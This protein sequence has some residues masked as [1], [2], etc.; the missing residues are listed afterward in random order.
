MDLSL[1]PW[2]EPIARQ[3]EPWLPALTI[4]GIVM[5]LASFIAIPWLLVRMP[6]DY[7]SVDYQPR[8]ERAL[9][10][11]VVWFAR[12][13]LAIVLLVAG[14]LML[15]LPGQGL[16]TI[17]IAI[18][19]ST[20]PGKYRLERA[21]MRRPGVYRAANWIRRKYNRPPLDYPGGRQGET[22]DAD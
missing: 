1:P 14:L 19:T 2:L 10:A 17:L 16:L 15:V 13:I 3:L 7:F 9:L 6:Q 22:S 12:N 18:M 20:F 4:S 8:E 11:W 21:I 5:A